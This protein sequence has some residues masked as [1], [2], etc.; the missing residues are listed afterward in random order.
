MI[1]KIIGGAGSRKTTAATA[2]TATDPEITSHFL[3]S[4]LLSRLEPGAVL[5][6]GTLTCGVY[7]GPGPFRWLIVRGPRKALVGLYRRNRAGLVRRLKSTPRALLPG[8]NQPRT[9]SRAKR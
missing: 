7:E 1:Q 4:V 6:L 8:L 2:P 3:A 5:P 9:L